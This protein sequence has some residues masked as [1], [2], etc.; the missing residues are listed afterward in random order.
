MVFQCTLNKL[1]YTDRSV[2]PIS[3]TVL[4]HACHSVSVTIKL[5]HKYVHTVVAIPHYVQSESG[6]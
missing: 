4:Y 6:L 2:T 3:V 5:Y 1:G